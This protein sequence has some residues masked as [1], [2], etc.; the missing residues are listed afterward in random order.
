MARLLLGGTMEMK[1]WRKES[2]LQGWSSLVPYALSAF[3]ALF[4]WH[5]NSTFVEN[6]PTP[7][8]DFSRD[9]RGA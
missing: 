5:V 6:V 7:F 4:L 3:L 9:L 8:P 1:E 2:P